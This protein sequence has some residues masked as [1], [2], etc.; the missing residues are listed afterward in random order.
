MQH[1]D[2]PQSLECAVAIMPSFHAAVFVRPARRHIFSRRRHGRPAPGGP[3]QAAAGWSIMPAGR[4]SRSGPRAAR[5]G[6]LDLDPGRARPP[7]AARGP[8]GAP[9]SLYRDSSGQGPDVALLHGWGING[10]VFD[11]ARAR[12]SAA[13]FACTRSTCPDTAARPGRR[14]RP[15]SRALRGASPSTCRRKL[16]WSAGRSAAWSRR[17]S[18][19]CSRRASRHWCCRDPP[20]SSAPRLGARRRRGGARGPRD[21]APQATGARRCGIRQLEVRGDE[22]RS[23]RCASSSARCSPI[24]RRARRRSPPASRCCARTDLRPE[25]AR[26]RRADAR[27]RRRVRPADAAGRGAALA[28]LGRARGSS[29][30]RAP[31]HVPFLSHRDASRRCSRG[32][33]RRRHERRRPCALERARGVPRSSRASASYDAHAVLQARGARPRC[34][35]GSTCWLRAG[36]RRRP[37]CGTGHAARALKR[38]WPRARVIALDLAPGDARAAR[39]A[40]VMAAW[41]RPAAGRRAAL[42]LRRP[43]DLVYAACCCRGSTI[44]SGVLGEVRRVLEPRGYFTFAT[45]GPDTLAELRAAWARGR[46]GAARAPLP[47][48]ARHRRCAGAGR[49]R[50]PGHGR[51][52]RRL[53]YPAA[54]R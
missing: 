10:G 21:A 52:P 22:R 1:D 4:R 16:R 20:A 53:T 40:A 12:P 51:R 7:G 33:S 36:A 25:L 27:D 15:T 19:R 39:R 41:L 8:A 45:L 31:R 38:R 43:V 34:S 37:R 5:T 6:P 17:A 3:R 44:S 9:L 50:G 46:H 23:R 29:R 24:G 28:A 2:G 54:A 30:S 26:V 49:V 35:R 11:G 18:R 47:R 14:A 42:P 32:V 13:A 48:H